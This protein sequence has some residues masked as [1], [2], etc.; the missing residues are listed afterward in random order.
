MK[1]AVFHPGTQHSWQTSTALQQMG[2]LEFYATSIF[3]DRARWPYR[4]ENYVPAAL[5]RR[6]GAEFRRFEHPALD[7]ANVRTVGMFEW[8]E[9]IAQRVGAHRL[10]VKFDRMGNRRFSRLL[11]DEILSDRPFGLWGFNSSSLETFLAGRA[12]GRTNILDRTLGDYRFY[13]RVMAE[14]FESHAEWFPDPLRAMDQKV[15]DRDD[16]EYDA[17]HHIVCGSEFCARTVR[18]NSPVPGIADKLHVLPYCFDEALFANAPAPQ[19]VDRSGPVKFLFVGQIGMRKGIH[20]LLEAIDQLPADKASLTLVGHMHMSR[21][22]FARYEDRVTYIPSVPRAAIPAIMAQHHAMV[23]PSY[24]EGSSLSLLEGLA[25]GL[26]L[27]HPPQAGNGATPETG[28]LLD[29]PS[30]DLTLA[31]ML[32]L[33]EDRDRLDY[34]RANAQ[35]EAARYTFAN[36]RANVLDFLRTVDL[37]TPTEAELAGR[38]MKAAR[39]V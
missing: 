23:F 26:A 19:P 10:S 4:V 31:A 37:V 33:I 27:V 7:P 39:P 9:R 6:L 16:A 28:I 20:H 30:T 29:R 35:A 13:N 22:V 25:S 15:I 5:G 11:E 38:A 1:L 32:E 18:E 3:Y 24:F 12:A 8:L 21:K 14:I 34:F 17:A 2:L 36:Y